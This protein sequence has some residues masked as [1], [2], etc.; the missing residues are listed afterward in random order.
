[1]LAKAF[2][3]DSTAVRNNAALACT[4][5]VFA[6]D[7]TL[8]DLIKLADD[9][10]ANLRQSAITALGVYANWRYSDAQMA[11]GKIALKAK[12]DLSDRGAAATLLAGAATFP[13]LG[14]VDDD[15][16]VF[17]ALLG[18]MNDELKALREVAFAPLKIA[19]SDGLG[20]DPSVTEKERAGPLAQWMEW[21]NKKSLAAGNAAKR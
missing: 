16:P 21:F 8:S 13:L 4:K 18:L 10:A 3:S 6:G 12:S 20:Y 17:Q 5:C 2:K 11:L 1:V 19:V 15:M 7:D 9:K 14:N